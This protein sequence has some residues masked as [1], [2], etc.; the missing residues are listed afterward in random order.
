[1]YRI[2]GALTGEASARIA[3]LL[4]SFWYELVF[5]AHAPL[6]DAVATYSLFAAIALLLTKSSRVSIAAF[7]TLAGLTIALRFQYSPAILIASIIAALRWRHEAWLAVP[8]FAIVIALVGTLDFYTWV[9]G[10]ARSRKTSD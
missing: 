5:F 8:T 7:G 4:G 1:M 9:Y 6:A 10:S 3:L 2:T